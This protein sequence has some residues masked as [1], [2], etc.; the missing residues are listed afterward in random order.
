MKR[1]AVLLLTVL[2]LWNVTACGQQSND[3]AAKYEYGLWFAVGRDSTRNDSSALVCETRDWETM[4][5]PLQLMQALLHGPESNDLYVPI[6]AGVRLVSVEFRETSKTV[7]VDLS[8]E[9][10]K[11]SGFELTLADYCI[12]LTLCQLP[13]V[14]NVRITAEGKTLAERN[15]QRLH[16]GDVLLSG[17]S[18]EPDTFLAALF[19][20]NK[21]GSLSVEYRQVSRVGSSEP[22]EIVLYELLRGPSATDIF[23]ALPSGTRV[24][25]LEV[26]GGICQV[27]LSRD[28]MTNAPQDPERAGLTL[29]ALVNSLCALAGVSQ[30][31]V[32]VDGEV[33][34]SF[35]GVTAGSQNLFASNLDLL[36]SQIKD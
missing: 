31:R 32:M 2:L 25:D 6:P 22:V 1:C 10:G 19:F 4:P 11:L 3:P 28:F 26:S 15:R 18:N 36:D 21:R 12:T 35:G 30:V 5:S 27:D 9:Y 23:E 16:S 34:T 13:E 7:L 14:E 29:Y 33:L 24:R 20:P 8:E 17:I